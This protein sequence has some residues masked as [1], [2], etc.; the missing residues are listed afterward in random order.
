MLY[1]KMFARR[2]YLVSFGEAVHVC[3][4]CSCRF[5]AAVSIG[6]INKFLRSEEIDEDSVSHD[7]MTG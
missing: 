7:Q 4:S 3:P 2:I 1:S 5:Q 6:R